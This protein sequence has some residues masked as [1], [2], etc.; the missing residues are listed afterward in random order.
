MGRGE[1]TLVARTSGLDFQAGSRAFHGNYMFS[2]EWFGVDKPRVL[3]DRISFP[4]DIMAMFEVSWE[5]VLSL[6]CT[7]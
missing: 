5:S 7:R 1:G 4:K 2:L 6:A 3:H